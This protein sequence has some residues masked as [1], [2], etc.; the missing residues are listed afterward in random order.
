MKNNPL[1]RT[2]FS[3]L[4]FHKT[5]PWEKA[6]IFS[7]TNLPS[8]ICCQMKKCRN[9]RVFNID[10]NCWVCTL[11]YGANKD[12]YNASLAASSLVNV[13]ARRFDSVV[14]VKARAREV[15]GCCS[16]RLR[17][18]SA[19][20]RTTDRF[21]LSRKERTSAGGRVSPAPPHPRYNA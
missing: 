20:A 6:W 11:K 15:T 10:S 2:N 5:I 1:R 18:R 13:V 21:T 19:A 17:A 9:A 8:G 14:V 16:L 3:F 7:N 12:N 4:C